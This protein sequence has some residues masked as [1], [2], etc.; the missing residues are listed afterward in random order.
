MRLADFRAQF[1]VT[2][3]RTYLITGAIAPASLPVQEAVATWMERAATRPL[4]NFERWSEKVDELRGRFARLIN[5]EADEI[6]VT[7]GTSRAAAIAVGL[8]AGTRGRDVLVDPTTYPSS[9][10]PWLTRTAKRMVTFRPELDPDSIAHTDDLAAA[11]V[12]HVA[13]HTGYR[14]HL[15][16]LATAAHRQGGLLVV[17]AA[18]SAGAVP[19]DVKREGIDVLVTTAMKWLL[20]LPGVGFL[21]VDR[22]LLELAGTTGD[23]GFLGRPVPGGWD[24]WPTDDL[25]PLPP[26][27]RRFELGVP[28][29]PSVAGTS[30]ALALLERVGIDR[31][32]AH[33]EALVGYCRLGLEQ[34]GFELATPPDPEHRAG[35]IAVRHPRAVR[36]A[37]QLAERDIDV[38]GF[39]WGL[40]VDPAGFTTFAEVDRFLDE[41]R[42]RNETL[43]RPV[44]D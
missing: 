42:S 1:P 24:A 12:S 41:V 39:D 17:D 4:S 10:Y 15:Q 16:K 25:P 5:A 14:H 9:L 30:A 44:L 40:R 6:A 32:S 36:L 11:V 13:W 31:I 38:M 37:A 7:D 23:V 2:Q 20:G 35:V 28:A 19:I 29:L 43:G 18:Q 3:R 26:G 8:L 33:V 22:R 27:A 21:Y 34:R